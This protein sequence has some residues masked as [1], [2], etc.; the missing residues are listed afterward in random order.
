MMSQRKRKE[1]IYARLK[2]LTAL[3]IIQDDLMVQGQM[4]GLRWTFTPCGYGT[5]AM[6]TN[7]VEWFLIGASAV[8]NA[9]ETGIV[10]VKP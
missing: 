1:R 7:D 2:A 10:K 4:P 9:T 5:R 6:T 3:G 8:V